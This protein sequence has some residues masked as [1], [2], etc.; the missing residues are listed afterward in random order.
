MTITWLEVRDGETIGRDP[1]ELS[2]PE[3]NQ[4][5]HS[6]RPVLQVIRER[7]LDCCVS[8]VGEVRKCVSRTCALWPYRM[9]TNPFTE[10]KGNV[11][12]F[13]KVRQSAHAQ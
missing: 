6:K 11:D 13:R 10:N 3:F 8:Q 1:R 5:G 12:A 7:C 4:L 2:V 9:G